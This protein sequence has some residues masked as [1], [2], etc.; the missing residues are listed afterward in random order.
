ML[1]NNKIIFYKALKTLFWIG[2]FLEKK[3]NKNKIVYN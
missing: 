1:K 3:Y 2:N